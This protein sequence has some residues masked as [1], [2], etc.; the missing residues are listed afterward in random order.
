[1]PSR[2]RSFPL[3]ALALALIMQAYYHGENS[4][5]GMENIPASDVSLNPYWG[6]DG[7]AEVG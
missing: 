3:W 2:P 4:T 1:M 6:F 5:N 7:G